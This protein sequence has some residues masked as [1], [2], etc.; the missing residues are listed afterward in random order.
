MK[1]QTRAKLQPSLIYRVSLNYVCPRKHIYT[2]RLLACTQNISMSLLKIQQ[3]IK[4]CD[5]NN[6]TFTLK[7][8]ADVYCCTASIYAAL[9]PIK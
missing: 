4:E 6:L 1:W 3:N 7:N 2:T 9:S 5:E 8:K